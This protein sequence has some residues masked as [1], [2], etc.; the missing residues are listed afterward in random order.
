MIIGI[1][2]EIMEGEKRVAAIPETIKK[3]VA[4][5]AGVLF[6]EGA[7]IGS[8]YADE[9]YKEAGAEIVSDVEEVFSRAEV[10]LKVKEPLFNEEKNKHEID[11]MHEG[12]YLI[13]FLHPASPANHKMIK[14][15]AEKGITGLTLD[16][17][18]RISRAQSMDAL[19]SMSA[20][21]GYKGII[22]GI[23]DI[24]KFV[25][26]VTSAV[27]R[28]QPATILVIG[29]GVAGLRALATAKGLGGTV[30]TTDIRPEA[31]KNAESLGAIILETGVPSDIAVSA[32]GMHANPL[33]AQWLQEERRHIAEILPKADIVFCSALIQGKVAPILITE[34]MVKMMQPGSCIVDISIDQGGN[35]EITTP[36]KI[37][38][39]Y[40]II[41]Q[42]IKNIPGMLSTSSTIMF[43]KNIYN[44]LSYL[45][46]DDKINLDMSDEIISSILVTRDR[47]ILHEGTLEAMGLK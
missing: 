47:K 27:G 26:F 36:G 19:S 29:A 13:S 41:I 30:Y 10:I 1:P 21:A 39:K 18:P 44:L 7:G 4:G 12:Q 2:K 38:I 14:H 8:H 6:Q 40:G 16:G 42:G 17:I 34:E 32:D 24:S 28:L 31:N 15:M 25:P 46:K 33:P 3:M 37:D 22:M 23:N 5:G 20:C 9:A 11:M 43:S 45:I 35:C